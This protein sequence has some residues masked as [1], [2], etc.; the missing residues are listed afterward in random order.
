MREGVIAES[1]KGDE[2]GDVEDEELLG[3]G[4][5]G[6][7]EKEVGVREGVVVKV[8]KG[9]GSIEDGESCGE[10]Q[11]ERVIWKE[12]EEGSLQG[13]RLAHAERLAGTGPIGGEPLA[14]GER[15]SVEIVEIGIG[16]CGE[17]AIADVADRALDTTLLVA[18]RRADWPGQVMIV[19]CECEQRGMKANRVPAP[20]E[21]GALEV[22]V[23]EHARHA[24]EEVEGQGVAAEESSM[25][26][27]R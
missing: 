16:P 26:A 2:Q 10:R 8:E 19:R 7:M 9:V 4:E 15:L 12:G 20:L 1:V 13:E 21:H 18:S 5:E 6:K 22:V 23:E 27:L 24:A 14:P 3:I 11:G 25:R 17:E